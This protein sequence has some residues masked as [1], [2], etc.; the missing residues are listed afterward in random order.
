MK[1]VVL[2]TGQP[3]DDV[4]HRLGHFEHWFARG[5]GWP[6]ER[7]F[8]VDALAGDPLPEPGVDGLIITG[9][10][11]SVHDRED[12]SVRAGG[13]IKR[14]IDGGSPVLGVCYGHQL[15]GDIYGGEVGVNPNGREMGVCM[16]EH[17]DDALFDGL[18]QAFPVIQTH[19]DAVNVAPTNAKV[20]AGNDNT[21]VQAMSIG[22]HVRCV[23]WHPEFTHD[24][25]A[26]YI[27]ARAHLV[28]SESGIDGL[29]AMRA[30]VRPV[31]SGKVILRNFA[32]HFLKAT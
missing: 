31:E 4:L 27:E 24:V 21:P 19:M 6:V 30:G 26:G 16:V 13:W 18:P 10:T 15:I 9:S 20:I 3:I 8:A 32:E 17:T 5:L 29:E 7:F 25:I 12:W 1:V 23:Q 2:R 14:V 22:D 11:H 28:E